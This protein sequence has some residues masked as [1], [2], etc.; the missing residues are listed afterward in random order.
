M[1]FFLNMIALKKRII[2][3]ESDTKYRKTE[4]LKGWIKKNYLMTQTKLNYPR[5][6]GALCCQTLC[7]N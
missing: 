6:V 7:K 3:I 1:L 4:G 2:A 5:I